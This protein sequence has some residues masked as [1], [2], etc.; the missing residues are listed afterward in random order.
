MAQS[1]VAIIIIGCLFILYMKDCFPIAVTTMLGMIAMV[2][3]GLLDYTEAFD[4]FS[5]SS[6]MLVLGMIIV[7]DALMESG[8]GGIIGHFLFRFT[9]GHERSFVIIV[10]LLAAGLS[11]FMTNAPLVAMFMSFIAAIADASGGKITKKNA[12]LPLAMG[13]LIGGTGT[14]IGSTAPLLANNVLKTY[15]VKPMEFFTPFPV[16]CAIVIVVAICYWLFLYKLQVRWFDFPEVKDEDELSM[17]KFPLDKRKATISLTVFFTCI[18]LFIVQPFDWDVGLISVTGCVVLI[19]AKCI[20]GKKAL[21]NM[22]WSALIT[23]GAALAIANGFV[24]SGAGEVIINWL[25]RIL[26][27]HVTNPIVLI[28]IFLLAGYGL[29][30]FMA[31]GSLVSMLSAIAVPMALDAGIDPTPVALSCVFGASLAMAT[32][33][34]STSI[35]MVEV[36]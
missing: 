19:A 28:T 8:V 36:A 27:D 25:I 11:G 29:S 34:A 24:K 20:D 16:A 1:T 13:A 18:I 5:N 31:N 15:G 21:R 7:V 35:T 32:P 17:D 9:G 30:L 6:V 2:F 23:L 14:L 22:Q 4:A 33:V 3:A 26:G 12:Y 10:F